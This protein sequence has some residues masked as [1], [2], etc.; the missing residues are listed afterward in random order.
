MSKKDCPEHPGVAEEYAGLIDLKS[1]VSLSLA[2]TR[3]LER[4]Q[5]KFDPS[6]EKCHSIFRE[7][8]KILN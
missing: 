3:E 7:V 6:C 4:L 2:E 1:R 5:G 8:T